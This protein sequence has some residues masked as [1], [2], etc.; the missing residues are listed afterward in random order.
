MQTKKLK[1]YVLQTTIETQ[2][3]KPDTNE[4]KTLKTK[5]HRRV[6][7]ARYTGCHDKNGE[8]IYEGDIIK[9]GLSA[10]YDDH[11]LFVTFDAEKAAF[12]AGS[13]SLQNV[14]CYGEVIGNKYEN[15]ELFTELLDRYQEKVKKVEDTLQA[16]ID[17]DVGE[18]ALNDDLLTTWEKVLDISLRLR[19][20]KKDSI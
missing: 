7:C 11:Y 19:D 12:Y 1:K 20:L 15:P 3:S 2:E 13:P 5:T 9:Y 6:V 10:N 8:E 16:V 18:E 17:I 14:G 4:T